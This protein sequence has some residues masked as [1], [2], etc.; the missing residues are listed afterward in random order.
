MANRKRQTSSSSREQRLSLKK[1]MLDVLTLRRMV[2][3]LSATGVRGRR[4]AGSSSRSR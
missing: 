2:R 3:E 1:R 4:S